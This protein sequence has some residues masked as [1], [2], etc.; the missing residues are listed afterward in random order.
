METL[1]PHKWY[2]ITEEASGDDIIQD[3][4]K[5]RN[6]LLACAR[7]PTE[8][9]TVIMGEGVSSRIL[10]AQLISYSPGMGILRLAGMKVVTLPKGVRDYEVLIVPSTHEAQVLL[11]ELN[12]LATILR[13]E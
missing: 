3:I 11:N 6:K 7:H 5:L 12:R 13:H 4:T 8:Y 2:G 10:K 1:I 9:L